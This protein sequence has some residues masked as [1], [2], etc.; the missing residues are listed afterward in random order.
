MYV[1]VIMINYDCEPVTL[2]K[3]RGNTQL[4]G[5][6]TVVDE[7]SRSNLQVVVDSTYKKIRLSLYFK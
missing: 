3:V 1:N 5:T 7:S 2:L 6:V 4:R